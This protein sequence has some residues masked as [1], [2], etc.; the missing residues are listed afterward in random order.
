LGLGSIWNVAN[1]VSE[2]VKQ[3]AGEVVRSVQQ[4]DWKSELSAFT[5]ELQADAQTVTTKAAEVVSHLPE[6]VHAPQTPK[7]SR[8]QQL[9]GA[10]AY[11][12][13]S[14]GKLQLCNP[15]KQ[16]CSMQ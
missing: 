13:T 9:P 8:H 5:E 4:T 2:A 3:T 15:I 11:M 1:A 10:E 12:S 14:S 7:V 16:F 6:K